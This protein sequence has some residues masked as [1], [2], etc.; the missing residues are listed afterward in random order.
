MED[1]VCWGMKVEIQANL[2]AVH[3]T[4]EFSGGVWP[5]RELRVFNW[6]SGGEIGVSVVG[7]AKNECLTYTTM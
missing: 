7:I 3:L 2:L 1:H 5:D 6:R 4:P